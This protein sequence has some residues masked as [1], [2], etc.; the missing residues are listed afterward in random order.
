MSE[1]V[2]R[3]LHEFSSFF[4][5]KVSFWLKNGCFLLNFT[6]DNRFLSLNPSINEPVNYAT[7]AAIEQ[8]VIELVYQGA[9]KDLWSFQGKV[10]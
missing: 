5:K 7:R 9:N 10:K 3:F 8:A 2:H 1:S 6:I 4:A